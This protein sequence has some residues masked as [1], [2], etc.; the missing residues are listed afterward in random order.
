MTPRTKIA[1]AMAAI[2]V[3]LLLLLLFG[4]SSAPLRAPTSDV[5]ST[6]NGP[7]RQS[8]ARAEKARGHLVTVGSG[9]PGTDEAVSQVSCQKTPCRTPT[10][11]KCTTE[12]CSTHTMGCQELTDD[13][14]RHLCEDV[15]TCFTDPANDCVTRGDP[16]KCWC[17][18]NPLT[19]VTDNSPP[20]QANGV[21]LKQVLAAGKSADAS[22]IRFR[23]MDPKT[24]L[25]LA[26][27]LVVCRGEYC[28]QE[29]GVK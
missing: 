6:A 27:T 16:L 28:T 14:E 11:N 29:C 2:A 23:F 3:V 15:Y 24:P 22:A 9:A 4:R 10:C 12:N 26:T 21:C 7:A 8:G 5:S 19:C 18:T 25:G 17:G 13:A 20:T 1:A